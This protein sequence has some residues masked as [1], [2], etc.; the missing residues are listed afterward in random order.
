M[1]ANINLIK[2][3]SYSVVNL[4]KQ[5]MSNKSPKQTLLNQFSGN[6]SNLLIVFYVQIMPDDLV[7]QL[8]RF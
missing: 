8:H 5:L 1:V 7:M 4:E 3:E 2:Q 6:D